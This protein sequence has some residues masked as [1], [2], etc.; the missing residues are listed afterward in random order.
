MNILCLYYTLALGFFFV[1]TIFPL[2]LLSRS[3][4][5]CVRFG[6]VRGNLGRLMKLWEMEKG[7]F[8]LSLC[9]FLVM[10]SSCVCNVMRYILL[11]DF[12]CVCVF[13][14]A[15]IVYV[16]V[17]YWE[18]YHQSQEATEKHLHRL[19]CEQFF[20]SFQSSAV[21]LW[22]SLGFPYQEF[23][24]KKQS[25]LTGFFSKP[26]VKNSQRFIYLFFLPPLSVIR[27]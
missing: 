2:W 17:C 6:L 7:N 9:V 1:Q 3:F 5:V 13:L 25:Q 18:F 20:F 4:C 27:L 12:L 19:D 26:K 8:F 10:I 24:P 22:K 21:G 15:S 14:P 16:N 11:S 23:E